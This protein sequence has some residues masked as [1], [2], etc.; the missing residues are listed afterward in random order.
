MRDIPFKERSWFARK[1]IDMKLGLEK[2]NRNTPIHVRFI[3][4]I[5]VAWMLVLMINMIINLLPS[6]QEHIKAIQ[7]FPD[8]W[9][10][11]LPI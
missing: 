9:G 2:F 1:K 7:C 5:M 10:C 4:F 6:P 8:Q 3:I 11:T